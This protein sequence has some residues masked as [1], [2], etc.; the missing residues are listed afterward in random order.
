MRMRSKSRRFLGVIL[1][2]VFVVAYAFMSMLVAIALLPDQPQWVH[3]L[4]YT[5]AG[6]LW[7]F[8]AMQIIRHMLLLVKS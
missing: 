3:L 4:Y 1:L 8:P 2:L 5:V 7:A 6:L